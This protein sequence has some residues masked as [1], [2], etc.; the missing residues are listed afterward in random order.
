MLPLASRFRAAGPP[1]CSPD[2]RNLPGPRQEETAAGWLG[3]RC[4]GTPAEQ[5][6]LSQSPGS[7][8]QASGA[9][10]LRPSSTW[11]SVAAAHGL[12]CP[13]AC[14]PPPQTRDQTRV[15]C[16]GRWTPVCCPAREGLSSLRILTEPRSFYPASLAPAQG[17]SA[18]K[19]LSRLLPGR[20]ERASC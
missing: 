3:G 1:A 17:P 8:C 15:L 6:L 10:A 14:G 16:T 19:N 20:T 18:Q 5:L 12:S 4:R 7:G 13:V 2:G 11:A 9:V